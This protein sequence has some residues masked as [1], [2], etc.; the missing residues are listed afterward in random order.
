MKY[1]K[2]AVTEHITLAGNFH[3]G[4]RPHPRT[5][6]TG[7]FTTLMVP[8]DILT[9]LTCCPATVVSWYGFGLYRGFMQPGSFFHLNSVKCS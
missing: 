6:F 7:S 1:L 5:L 9:R 8:K 4:K 3:L 2:T